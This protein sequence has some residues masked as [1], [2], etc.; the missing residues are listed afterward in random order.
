[1]LKIELSFD[2]SVLLLDIHPKKTNSKD[3]CTTVFIVALFTITKTQKQPL[4]YEWI[5]KA[6]AYI[7]NG[8]LLSYKMNEILPFAAT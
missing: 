3:E 8:I 6:W 5:K 1:M 4:A 7:Y 2:T